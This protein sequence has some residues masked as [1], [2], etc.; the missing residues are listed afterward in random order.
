MISEHDI[1]LLICKLLE[2]IPDATHGN[3]DSETI[4]FRV[5]EIWVKKIKNYLMEEKR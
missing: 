5:E 4:R 2:D 3:Y 1:K